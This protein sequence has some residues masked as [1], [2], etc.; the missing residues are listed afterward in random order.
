MLLRRTLIVGFLIT[1]LPALTG[2]FHKEGEGKFNLLSIDTTVLANGT[3]GQAYSQTLKAHG[4][5]LPYLWS[6]SSGALPGGLLLDA[7]TGEISGTPTAAGAVNF[8]VRVNDASDSFQTAQRSLSLTI[9]SSVPALDITTTAL[10]DGV[11]GMAYSQTL[12]ATG[13]ALPYRWSLSSGALPGGLS[14][15]ASTGEISGSPTVAGTFNLTVQVDDASAPALNDQQA[16]SLT[17]LPSVPALD[18]T[19]TALPDGVVGMFYSQTLQATGGMTPYQW[20]LAAG[21]PPD[22]LILDS[23][24]V[25]S[26][27]PTADGAV[28]FTAQ[29]DDAGIP[30]QTDQQALAI[31]INLAAP[32]AQVEQLVSVRSDGALAGNSSSIDASSSAD[33]RFVAFTSLASDLV[34][35]DLNNVLDVFVRD[36]IAG[37]T[38]RV[39]VAS[40]GAEGDGNSEHPSISADGRFVAFTSFARNLVPGDGNLEAD[41]FV[42]DR[43]ADGNGVFD[44]PGAIST[45]RVSV[46]TLTG[47]EGNSRSTN[48]A[49]TPD[50]RFV[51][52]AGPNTLVANDTNFAEDVFV[53][54]RDVDTNGVFDEANTPGMEDK[55][56]TLR[57]SLDSAGVQGNTTSENP[58]ISADGRFVAFDSFASNLVADDTNNT[59]DVF[60]R[61]T[62]TGITVRVSVDS[63]GAQDANGSFLASN[64]SISADGRFVAFESSASNLVPGDTNMHSDVFVHDRDADGD[65]VFDESGAISTVRVSV[66]SNGAQHNNVGS[67][68][69]LPSISADGRFVAFASSAVDLVPGD[70]NSVVDI[71][72]HDRDADGDGVFDEPGNITTVRVS[73]NSNGVE[74]NTVN[75]SQ[76]PS[77]SADG[78]F[79]AFT[80]GASNF[81]LLDANGVFDVFL[82]GTGRP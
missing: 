2:C 61:D 25:I 81:S 67:I 31:R 13:G 77:I 71:F 58:S 22:G 50:G 21:A 38:V 82:A 49:I 40:D 3:E 8:T 6:V 1:L 11:V 51:A 43:D 79:V 27:T 14:L 64:P 19:T 12:K 39:S 17:I 56:I 74:G 80:S 66:D 29:V 42:H 18:I 15:D 10:P 68:A 30:S 23:T 28:N 37:S 32:Q 46:N 65:G 34:S 5:T 16:L 35:M 45:V 60:V 47:A 4:G 24:G 63:N 53:H 44:E 20:S 72:V 70:N 26:G 41:I 55:V 7:S 48:P 75:G 54:D 69:A 59:P 78:R 52:F 33:G 57:V 9:L 76:I 62:M 73:V 36:T